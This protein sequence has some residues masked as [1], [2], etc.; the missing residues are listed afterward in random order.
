MKRRSVHV[1]L[2]LRCYSNLLWCIKEPQNGIYCLN[3]LKKK[4]TTWRRRLCFIPEVSCSVL[5]VGV[6]SVSSLLCNVFFTTWEHDVWC[7]SSMLVEHSNSNWGGRV[8]GKAQLRW[9]V[10]SHTVS[11][12]VDLSV[13]EL[14]DG[15]RGI[16]G[17]VDSV[18]SDRVQLL[19]SMA[20]I[21][22]VFC[23]LATRGDEILLGKLAMSRIT[24]TKTKTVITGKK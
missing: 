7:K 9:K 5:S 4:D 20:S 16:L 1:P 15:Y 22:C 3:L 23:R 13:I 2:E 18:T 21:R 11:W 8:F 24:L 6:L 12:W 19:A 14:L 10:T 17:Q